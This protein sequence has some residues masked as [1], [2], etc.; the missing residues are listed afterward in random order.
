MT[1]WRKV[2]LTRLGRIL[3]LNSHLAHLE[4]DMANQIERRLYIHLHARCVMDS[5]SLVSLCTEI[6]AA[7]AHDLTEGEQ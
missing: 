6:G 7:V 5:D 4:Q 3:E 2:A 1:D